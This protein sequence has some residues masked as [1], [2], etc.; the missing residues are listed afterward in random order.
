MSYFS[1]IKEHSG[2]THFVVLLTRILVGL[3][4]IFLHGL[5][6]LE[7]LMGNDEVKFYSFV[8]LGAE[9]TLI[10]ATVLEMVA[11]FLI[12][13]GLFTR[14]ASLILIAVMSVAAFA[15]HSGDPVSVREASLLYFTI[16]LMI[17]ALGP[18]KYS[19]DALIS[20]RGGSKW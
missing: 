16:F 2:F 6:K 15:V 13:I 4:M 8:G 11:G 10:L 1:S 18:R 9:N 5:P 3:G 17:L 20:K 12:M 14:G 7:R 19:V